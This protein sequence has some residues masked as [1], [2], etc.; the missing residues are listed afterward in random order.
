VVTAANRRSGEFF[1]FNKAKC[2]VGLTSVGNRRGVERR[3]GRRVGRREGRR[4]WRACVALGGPSRR[5]VFFLF[6]ACF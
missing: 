4:L 2:L 6:L 1:Y 5:Y 3:V